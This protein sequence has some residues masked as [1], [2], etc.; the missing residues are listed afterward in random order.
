M[1]NLTIKGRW[2]LGPGI[3]PH[4]DARIGRLAAGL[5]QGEQRAGRSSGYLEFTGAS[6]CKYLEAMME[7]LYGQ[8]PRG[9]GPMYRLSDA[10]GL[11]HRPLLWAQVSELRYL[12]SGQDTGI[13]L[14]LHDF[15]PDPASV[16][17]P[18]DQLRDAIARLHDATAHRL[19][20]ATEIGVTAWFRFE[21]GA[22]ELVAGLQRKEGLRSLVSM[23]EAWRRSRTHRAL[24]GG[25]A[26]VLGP[27]SGRWQSWVG[28]PR[29]DAQRVGIAG[30]CSAQLQRA[31]RDLKL[32][33][34]QPTP[35]TKSGALD[36]GMPEDG[37]GTIVGIVDFGCDFAHPSFLRTGDPDRSRILA[38]WDQND[39]PESTLAPPALAAP[40]HAAVTVGGKSHAFG[41]GRLFEQPQID[42]ALRIWHS[43]HSQD[44]EAPYGLLGY[45]PH[46]HHYTAQ[47]PGTSGGPEGAHGTIV[48]EIAAGGP[49]VAIGGDPNDRPVVRGVASGADIVF[50]QVRRHVRPDGRQALNLNDVVDAVA[51]V[52]HVAE[53]QTPPRPCVVNLSLNTMSGPHDGDGY[54]E[55]R[56]ASLLRSGSAGP[57]AEGRAVVIAAGNLPEMSFQLQRWQHLADTVRPGQTFSFCWR[58]DAN[59]KT[60]NSIEIWY[61]ARQAW[62]RLSLKSPDGTVIGTV[63]PGQA[64]EIFVDGTLRGSVVG[65]RLMPASAQAGPLPAS[66]TAAGRHVILIEIASDFATETFWTV[67]LACVDLKHKGLD[68]GD[69][70]PFHAWLERDDNGQ[71][72]LCRSDELPVPETRDQL[73]TIGTLSCG[74]DTI[75]VGASNTDASSA[76]LWNLSAS[77]PRIDDLS[78]PELLA[79]GHFVRVIRSKAGAGGSPGWN[80][81]PSG[82]SLAAPFVAGTIACMY[83]LAPKATLAQVREALTASARPLVNPPQG[84]DQK[85]G[86]GQLNPAA[87]LDHLRRMPR[88]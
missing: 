17:A 65:S 16:L 30:G 39:K 36:Y 64:G 19:H 81:P 44:S 74:T 72:G 59:D 41:Y 13:A 73:T 6:A 27:A 68:S 42:E 55:R 20:D 23:P 66:D 51:F 58:I 1:S 56:I 10:L 62:L 83:Q 2:G 85:L 49:R 47:R 84:S 38:L 88:P 7:V 15:N 82:T 70:I 45:D 76:D 8:R 33:D 78:K 67:E 71:S 75:V 53:R 37:T 69:P 12:T 18:A 61:E 25:A 24:F 77:G 11:H 32:G 48:M 9:S 31:M 35:Q 86:H 54:F 63:A 50:V 46:D 57:K 5:Q 43:Q 4:F 3:D 34:P 26:P 22:A 28:A 14:P 60:R 29:F 21:V 87:A 80:N 40:A 79:P 52:F